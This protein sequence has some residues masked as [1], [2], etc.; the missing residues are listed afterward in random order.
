MSSVDICNRALQKIGAKRITSLSEDS[1]N[2]RS[3][4]NAYDSLRLSLLNSHN[5]Y[6]A[7]KRSALAADANP[8]SWGR[9]NSFPLPSDFVRLINQYPEDTSNTK[10]WVL[11]GHS[12]LTDDDAPLDI[13]YIYDLQETGTMNPLFIEALAALIAMEICDEIVQSNAKKQTLI[14]EY[15]RVIKEAKKANAIQQ[16]PAVPPED[17]WI[18]VR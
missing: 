9:S 10:D 16:V 8:P 18:T 13:R 5:W 17:Y 2:A 11:E 14:A 7:I 1:R 3:C 6:C 4:N 15:D 12:I